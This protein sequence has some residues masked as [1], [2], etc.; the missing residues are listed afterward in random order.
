MAPFPLALYC[1][2]IGGLAGNKV[3]SELDRKKQDNGLKT[4]LWQILLPCETPLSRIFQEFH[5]HLK[6]T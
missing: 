5:R 2:L 6:E 3:G 4:L 1:G